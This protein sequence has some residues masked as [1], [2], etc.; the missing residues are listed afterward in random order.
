MN[1]E[2]RLFRKYLE[3]H[4][5]TNYFLKYGELYDTYIQDLSMQTSLLKIGEMA[6]TDSSMPDQTPTA[7]DNAQFARSILQY[8]LADALGINKSTTDQTRLL[9][10]V[11]KE[12]LE[13]WGMSPEDIHTNT[14]NYDQN[15]T[16]ENYRTQFINA[17]IIKALGMPDNEVWRAF[18]AEINH[19]GNRNKKG[20]KFDLVPDFFV[21]MLK[22]TDTLYNDSIR[23]KYLRNLRDYIE[24][25]ESTPLDVQAH[26][27]DERIKKNSG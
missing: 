25:V 2:N 26:P 10:E 11:L 19:P 18:I 1:K 14:K 7:S 4:L 12:S 27:T 16:V 24:S 17:H 23:E 3:P 15:I 9:V 22:R 6:N 20:H 13:T 21:L 8:K 5:T